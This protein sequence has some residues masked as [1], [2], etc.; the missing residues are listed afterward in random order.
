MTGEKKARQF[1]E[2][3]IKEIVHRVFLCS[4]PNG[5]RLAERLVMEFGKCQG[6]LGLCPN[7]VA[8]RV[9]GVLETMP[10][11]YR[12]MWEGLKDW[13]AQ[14]DVRIDRHGLGSPEEIEQQTVLRTVLRHMFESERIYP[15]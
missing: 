12:D 9:R 2:A 4:G 15:K 3:A 6:G 8:A 13:L 7:A 5:G 1:R 10:D 11:Q 14:E